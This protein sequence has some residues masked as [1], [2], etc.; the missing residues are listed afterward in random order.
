MKAYFKHF[1]F[2]IT[3]QVHQQTTI[4]LLQ[5][6]ANAQNVSF[7]I[8]LWWPNHIINPVDKLNQIILW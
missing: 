7:R 3:L 2:L 1:K 8:S 6:R 5:R 4:Y